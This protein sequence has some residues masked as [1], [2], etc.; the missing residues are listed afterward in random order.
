MEPV[1]LSERFATCTFTPVTKDVAS[2]SP[3][4]TSAEGS[5]ICTSYYLDS[6]GRSSFLL[7]LQLRCSSKEDVDHMI[8]SRCLRPAPNNI[9]VDEEDEPPTSSAYAFRLEAQCHGIEG[10]K[11]VTA[12]GITILSCTVEGNSILLDTEVVVRAS[13]Q[14]V[15]EHDRR[16]NTGAHHPSSLETTRLEVTAVLAH[17]KPT[18]QQRPVASGLLAL[19]LGGG[20]MLLSGLAKAPSNLQ[21]NE[22]RLRA[23]SIEVSLKHALNISVKNVGGASHGSTFVSL[24]M[25][26][27]NSHSEPVTITNIALHPGLSRQDTALFLKDRSMPGGGRAVTDMSKYVQWGYAPRTEPQ[28]PLTLQPYEAY[29]TV[30]TVNAGHDLRSRT[31]ASP[32]SVTAVVGKQDE[33]RRPQVVAAA[34]AHWTTGRI[35][36]EPTDAF[37]IDMSLEEKSCNVGDPVVVS[38]RVLNLSGDTRDLMLLMAKDDEKSVETEASGPD[39]AVVSK[40][41]GYTFGVW[42]LS[43]DEDGTTLKSSDHELLALDAALLLGEVKGQ[44]SVDV[45]LRFVPLREGTLEVP[46]FMLYDRAEGEWYSCDHK[47]RIVAAAKK[48]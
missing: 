42:G 18:T 48:D 8:A 29:S 25:M 9:T 1:N 47:L 7:P 15:P 19:E 34:D 16:S 21:A 4:T 40:V 31:F 20:S 13:S 39:A 12:E 2:F 35:A 37:R 44:H 26:H 28:L 43:G 24:T 6:S 11:T 41:N 46:N 17:H 36:V 27:A 33:D 5:W 14:L 22:T 30:I 23:I 45:E 3:I 38:V 32:I 10:S